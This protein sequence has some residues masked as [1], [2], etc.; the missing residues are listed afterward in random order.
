MCLL[1]STYFVKVSAATLSQFLWVLILLIL[2]LTDYLTIIGLLLDFMN[3][4]FHCY[5]WFKG[6]QLIAGLHVARIKA[7]VYN[8]HQQERINKHEL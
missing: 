6:M 3:S 8:D 7:K 5:Q 2:D 4:Q 1:S